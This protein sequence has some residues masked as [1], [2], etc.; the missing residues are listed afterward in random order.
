[1]N[2]IPFL[3]VAAATGAFSAADLPGAWSGF[4]VHDGDSTL[5]ALELEPAAEGRTRIK[6]TI[7]AIWIDRMTIDEVNAVV[8]G[9]SVSLGLF[10]FVRDAAY[11]SLHGVVP[12]AL[13]P[14]Y[15]VPLTLRRVA[16]PPPVPRPALDAP[17]PATA[18]TFRGESP[19]WAGT[20]YAHGLVY[21]GD[22]GGVLHA[23][24]AKS[25]GERWRFRAAG[26]I[27]G[28][29]LVVGNDL[30]LCAD[31]GLVR[32]LDA[33]TGKLRWEARVESTV[34]RYPI[35][36]PRTIWDRFGAD[37]VLA[38]GRLY[39][40]THDGRMVAL[41]PADGARRWQFPTG[42]AILAAPSV[43][44]GRAFFGSYDGHVYT[45][46]AATGALAWK[47]DAR[48]PVVS[49]PALAGDRV[50]IGSRSYDL[51]A[52]DARRGTQLW[53]RYFW[54]SWVESSVAVVD[55]LAYVGSSDASAVHAVDVRDG[56]IAWTA[57][58][59]GWAWGPPTV[60][61]DRVYIGTV[62]EASTDGRQ[63]GA[64]NVI[65]RR[66]GRLIARLPA[67]PK[68]SGQFGYAGA[69]ALG[70]GLVFFP[71]LDGTIVALPQ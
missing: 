69:A 33:R 31:D 6:A 43:A 68:E 25:G 57:P 49:T 34:V 70:Q 54:F 61:G 62:G 53:K 23:L 48:K 8:R 14:V 59:R 9:D 66:D 7:P 35:D 47:F 60:A 20:T 64:A 21:A 37:P 24:D 51:F 32:R 18:W 26:A 36:D 55:G 30:F 39:V 11:G 29:A 2:P 56:R 12:A 45:V 4:A 17:E 5:I 71:G 46:D 28:R 13:L 22:D 63:V 50:I 65:D 1:M 58:V 38:G 52:L 40:G 44:G 10:R 19:F 15:T 67:P 3:L 16:A 42:G 27:R 41:D